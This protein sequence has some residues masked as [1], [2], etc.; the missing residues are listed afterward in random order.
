MKKIAEVFILSLFLC[1]TFMKMVDAQNLAADLIIVNANVRTMD[2]S[3][4]NAEAVAVMG[5]RI[6]AVG[7]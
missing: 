4:P 1:L 6:V 5:N 2:A 3:K 7:T